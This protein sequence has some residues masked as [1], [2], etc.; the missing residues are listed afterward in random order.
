MKIYLFWDVTTCNLVEEHRSRSNGCTLTQ[1]HIEG[2]STV[3]LAMSWSHVGGAEVRLHSFLTSALDGG[4]S[5][6][7]LCHFICAKQPWYPPNRRMGGPQS[8]KKKSNAQYTTF[9]KLVL[10]LVVIRL[11]DV[12]FLGAF[13]KLRK[14]SISFIMSA[15]PSAWNNSLISEVRSREGQL[16]QPQYRRLI[17]YGVVF[18]HMFRGSNRSTPL[19]PPTT[20]ESLSNFFSYTYNY[21]ITMNV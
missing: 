15:C 6:S 3:L 16:P 1:R 18:I 19:E 4:E 10:R 2:R 5:S 7:R 17:R 11:T 14:E 13:A 9:K 12:I 20:P 21:I 8:Y